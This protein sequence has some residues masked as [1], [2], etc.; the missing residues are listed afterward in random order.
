VQT[1]PSEEIAGLCE[2]LDS[3]PLAVE[4]AAARTKALSPAQILERLS[5]WLDRTR[6]VRRAAATLTKAAEFDRSCGDEHHDSGVESWLAIS[7]SLDSRDDWARLHARESLRLAG[8]LGAGEVAAMALLVASRLAVA[9]CP[10]QA[11][12]SLGGADGILERVAAQR[13]ELVPG[14]NGQVT[15]ELQDRL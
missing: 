15:V 14:M 5:H 9:E 1:E 11:A 13:R 6:D 12:T 3:L 2:R 10:E 4:L 8:Q 7:R